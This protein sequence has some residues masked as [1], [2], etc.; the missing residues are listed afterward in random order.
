MK[1][2]KIYN[3]FN[4]SKEDKKNSVTHGWKG[5]KTFVILWFVASSL[6]IGLTLF[7]IFLTAL[8]S[9]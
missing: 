9:K 2:F 1:S 5:V 8:F 6:I 4:L 7:I 3:D